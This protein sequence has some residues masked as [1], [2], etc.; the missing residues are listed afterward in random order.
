MDPYTDPALWRASLYHVLDGA[1]AWIGVALV[2]VGLTAA[3]GM[4][5][6]ALVGLGVLA[7]LLR[8]AR[9][10]GKLERRRARA[11]LGLE[12]AEPAPLDHRDLTFVDRVRA[13][14]RDAVAWRAIAYLIV[15]FPLGLA[16]STA[17]LTAW[18]VVVYLLS[19]PLEAVVDGH[20]D[21]LEGTDTTAKLLAGGTLFF[22]AGLA[23]LAVLPFVVRVIAAVSRWLVR[24]LLGPDPDVRIR[25]LEGQRSSAV[26]SADVDRRRIEQDLHDG[27][28]VRLT[29]LAMQLGLAREAIGEGADRTR[30]AELVGDAH[31]QAK[32]ALREIRDLARGIHPAILTDRG[33]DAALA[34]MVG[35]LPTPV[36]LEVD[37]TPRPD[38]AV[39]SVAYFVAAEA[40]TNAVRHADSP[41]VGLRVVREGDELVVEVRDRG[42][43]GADPSRGTGL[44]NLRERVEATGGELTVMSPEGVGTLVRAVMPCG[45]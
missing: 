4:I 25:Q 10:V 13:T 35:R 36:D 15:R 19:V 7:V 23:A 1:V 17:M 32:L 45:S 31:D 27:A 37:V 40:V 39:E 38:P 41:E 21:V 14:L 22:L 28:Q 3:V 26:R 30:I 16:A 24:A 43:G 33:L 8:V 9:W 20:I 12:V 5:P 34:S 11:L 42:C 44:D 29:A 6:F 18:S 2:G